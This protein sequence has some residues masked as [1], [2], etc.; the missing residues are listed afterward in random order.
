MN[1][2]E[3]RLHN[4]EVM[5]VS[6]WALIED[7]MPPVYRE[8]IDEMMEDYFNANDSLGADFDTSRQF[9]TREQ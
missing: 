2:L 8:T 6:L 3:K 7:T 5:L 9:Y 1:D 4:T